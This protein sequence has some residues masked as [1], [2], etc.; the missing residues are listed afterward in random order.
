VPRATNGIFSSP[1]S[2]VPPT[3]ND[4]TVGHRTR[5][6]PDYLSPPL[7]RSARARKP[8]PAYHLQATVAE[9]SSSAGVT[10][11]GSFL[12][13]RK[14][15]K[16][17]NPLYALLREKELEDKRGT[18]C[19]ALRLAEEA[20][21]EGSRE[22]SIGFDDEFDTM[23]QLCLADEQAAWKAVRESRKSSPVSSGDVEGFIIGDR[24]SK[25]L[26]AVAGEVINKILAG[27]KD[28]KGQERTQKTDQKMASGVP[29][30]IQ[31]SDE[32]M[33]VDLPSIPPLSGHPILT[34][35]D[36][37]LGSDGMRLLRT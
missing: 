1:L 25:M 21:R 33:E 27:D 36:R 32:D 17:M 16:A 15:S 18:S 24:E 4:A 34:C 35:L 26:G 10:K 7:R 14:K 8:A 11:L 12:P 13:S 29:L 3:P 28:S 6:T 22:A 19:A 30:W 31:S 2:S 20:M 5:R 23:N 37:L 9:S